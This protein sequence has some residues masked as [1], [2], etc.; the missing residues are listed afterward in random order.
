V[1]E[2]IAFV[3]GDGDLSKNQSLRYGLLFV[4][5]HTI[6]VDQVGKVDHFFWGDGEARKSAVPVER[7]WVRLLFP[8]ANKNSLYIIMD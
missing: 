6:S 1:S 4:H 2:F 3:G 7:R 8:A 5:L